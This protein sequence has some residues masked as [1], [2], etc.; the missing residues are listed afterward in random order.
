MGLFDKLKKNADKA[1]GLAEKNADK[2]AEGVNK[3][4]DMVDEKTKG[5]F[6]DKLDKVDDAIDKFAK[7]SKPDSEAE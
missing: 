5:K 2:I 7:D 4:T 3:A 1:K 6:S